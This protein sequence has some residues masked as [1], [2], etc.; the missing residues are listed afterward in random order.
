MSKGSVSVK[1]IKE[2]VQNNLNRIDELKPGTPE[3][4]ELLIQSNNL[5]KQLG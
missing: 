2:K 3:R 4:R 1:E 5:L